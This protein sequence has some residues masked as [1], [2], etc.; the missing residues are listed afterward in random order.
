MCGLG[1]EGT[2]KSC[3]CWNASSQ[4][5]KTRK[6]FFFPKGAKIVLNI[7]NCQS[8]IPYQLAAGLHQFSLSTWSRICHPLL[9]ST[10]IIP[11]P[12]VCR[13]KIRRY[14]TDTQ[15]KTKK[16]THHTGVTLSEVPS[17]GM[18]E[19][20]TSFIL[21]TWEKLLCGP[22]KTSSS[23]SKPGSPVLWKPQLPLRGDKRCLGSKLSWWQFW[24]ETLSQKGM[25][26]LG[27]KPAGFSERAIV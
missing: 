7:Q 27:V 3:L 20:W 8:Q 26:M 14:V 22:G 16:L 23:R 2:L 1:S 11:T 19:M 15:L 5:T 25:E 18:S 24:W 9:T 17:W 12:T 10:S 6:L 13:K 4:V 21:S